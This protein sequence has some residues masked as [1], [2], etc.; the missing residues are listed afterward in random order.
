[1]GKSFTRIFSVFLLLWGL[2]FHVAYG[3]AFVADNSVPTVSS[4]A[5]PE[6]FLTKFVVAFDV[7]PQISDAGGE[8]V[9]YKN[10]VSF[11]TMAITKTSSNI[12]VDG[13]TIKITHGISSFVQGE[14]YSVEITDGA[15]VGLGALLKDTYVFTIGD[16]APKVDATYTTLGFDSGYY[17]KKVGIYGISPSITQTDSL[18]LYFNEDVKVGS[19]TVEIYSLDGVLAKAAM[20]VTIAA[21]KRTVTLGDL[22]GLTPNEEYYV[23]VNPGIVTDLIESKAYAGMTDVKVW[24]FLL[25]DD[26]LYMQYLMPNSSNVPVN[27]KLTINFD[28]PVELTNTGYIALYK[29]AAG[30]EAVQR[31]QGDNLTS[32]FSVVGNMVIIN[33][34]ELDPNTQY[35]VEVVEGT[36]ASADDNTILQAAIL[37]TDWTFTTEVNAKPVIIVDS[38]I[39]AKDDINVLSATD[40]QITFDMPVEAGTGSIQ[41]HASNG[42]VAMNFDV[43]GKDVTF[44]GRNVLIHLSDLVESNQYYMII[45]STAIRNTSYT[46]EYCEGIVA[47]FEWKFSVGDFTAP[48]LITATPTGGETITDTH[49]VLKMTFNEIVMVGSG[50]SITIYD[51]A[52]NTLTLTIP[53]VPTMIH[54]KEVTVNYTS[55]TGLEK[56]TEY[57][58]LVDGLAMQDLVGNALAGVSDVTA[59]TFKT[60]AVFPTGLDSEN[61]SLEFNIYPN[62]FVDH[63]DITNAYELSKVV[64]TNITGQVVKEVVNPSERIPLN[65]LRSG[66]YFI[67][68]YNK[69]NVITKS[70]K[71]VK[72]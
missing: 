36:F 33:I 25:K 20:A 34:T 44:S 49:P 31:W 52:T 40:L 51:V 9:I 3:I 68:L 29:S 35:F 2:S 62:P 63:V 56:N 38:Y 72:R 11:K 12:V 6:D 10:N 50:G 24:K 18:N 61:G 46:P 53:I 67:T 64:F 55:A 47:P 60:G 13:N 42:S 1:M 28:R 37:R 30:G 54:G 41:L 57:Y 27:T 5:N 4:N 59:W 65:E 14:I 15:I 23:L 43:Q 19:G 70:A 8:I 48:N 32:V 26:A 21:D 45:P 17:P 71:I 58:V 16:V 22:T 66:I 39:P 69:D 7:V